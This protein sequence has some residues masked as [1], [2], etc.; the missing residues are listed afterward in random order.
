MYGTEEVH[1]FTPSYYFTSWQK[2]DYADRQES[3]RV[4]YYWAWRNLLNFNLKPGKN[5]N[6]TLMLGPGND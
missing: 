5:Q 3:I 6:L 2:N 4:N 1:S